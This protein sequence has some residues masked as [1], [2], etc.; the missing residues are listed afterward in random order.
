MGA[1]VRYRCVLKQ[2]DENWLTE[3]K[4]Y[5]GDVVFSPKEFSGNQ[6]ILITRADDGF[7]AYARLNQFELYKEVGE[8][9]GV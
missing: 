8:S 7:S 4:I 2:K 5:A 9:L 3:G 6:W 1:D